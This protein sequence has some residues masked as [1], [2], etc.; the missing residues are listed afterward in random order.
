[1]K[2]DFPSESFLLPPYLCFPKIQN[3][4]LDNAFF[5]SESCCEPFIMVM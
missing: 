4:L 2:T 5:R 3:A 1:M